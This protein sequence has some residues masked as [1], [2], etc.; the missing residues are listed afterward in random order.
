MKIRVFLVGKTKSAALKK[1]IDIY[2]KRL[3]HYVRIEECVVRD[4]SKG[5]PEQVREE[6][7]K[8]LLSR[9]DEREFVVLLDE[10]GELPDTRKFAAK[11]EHAMV[12]G[13]D[14]AFII[15]G[16]WGVS[17]AVRD[18]ADWIWALS[19]LTFPHQLVRL[20]FIEQLYRAFTVIRREPYHH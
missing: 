2:W 6:E 15:G 7:G 17:D 5:R 3:G 16:A 8:R 19:P 1:E 4:E 12:S 13:K 9:L 11:V 14:L 18:R 10:K 20:I